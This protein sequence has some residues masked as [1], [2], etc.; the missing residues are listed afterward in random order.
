MSRFVSLS[1]T[2]RIFAIQNPPLQSVAFQLPSRLRAPAEERLN[3][4]DQPLK[5]NGLQF[6]FVTAGS[7]CLL[8]A[9]FLG[10]GSEDDDRDVFRFRLVFQTAGRLPA[11]N[12][13]KIEIHYD[14]VGLQ[15]FRPFDALRAVH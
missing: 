15:C 10:I 1:S 7:E 9:F 8:P 6:E 5:V 12:P 11:I 4:P 2:S 14:D 3:L 13:W